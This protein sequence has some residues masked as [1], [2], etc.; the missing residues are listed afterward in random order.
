MQADNP[1]P[2]SLPDEPHYLRGPVAA[3]LCPVTPHP[4]LTQICV[5]SKPMA[6]LMD[7][8]L[9]KIIFFKKNVVTYRVRNEAN[10]KTSLSC[11][12]VYNCK[13]LL[14]VLVDGFNQE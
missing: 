2:V 7:A 8:C 14:N 1:R 11:P 10:S 6:K 9:E 12:D 5:R 4:T 13:T 3:Q